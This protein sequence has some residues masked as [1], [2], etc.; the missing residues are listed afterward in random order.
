[1]CFLPRRGEFVFGPLRAPLLLVHK[2]GET[3]ARPPPGRTGRAPSE[4]MSSCMAGTSSSSLLLLLLLFAPE[5]SV[6]NRYA[7][8][9]VTP[10]AEKKKSTS[11]A[12]PYKI[13]R[14]STQVTQTLLGANVVSFLA[15]MRGEKMFALLAKSDAAIRRGGYHRFVTPCLLHGSVGH[16]LV[17][18]YSLHNLGKTVE[19]YLGADRFLVVYLASA[20]SGNALSFVVGNSPLSVGASGAIFGLL[21]CWGTFLYLNS[22]FFARRGVRVG[23]SLGPLAQ[24]CAINAF[25]GLQP[26]S[27]IDN[28]GH[29]G[30]LVGGAITAF[31]IGPR[32]SE[33]RLPSSGGSFV[34]D[35]PLLRLP[36]VMKTPAR[37]QTR[38]AKA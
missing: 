5:P 25:L 4:Q 19:P 3:R 20:V 8:G 28:M 35:A 9:Q 37:R 24:T 11:T 10:Y 23:D 27:R 12:Q 2:T 30:G 17:N 26:G 33:R 1:M 14:Q 31:L 36:G 38:S 7:P 22:D 21:G 32:L 34:V 18:S 6:A 16:L 29:L 15:T 13:K